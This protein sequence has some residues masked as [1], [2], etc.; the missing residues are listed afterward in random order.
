[1]IIDSVHETFK[2]KFH[3]Y[4]DLCSSRYPEQYPSPARSSNQAA[5]LSEIVWSIY[6]HDQFTRE[7]PDHESELKLV[8]VESTV[9][10]LS[11]ISTFA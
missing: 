7:L 3:L 1:V 9:N 10:S 2:D 8:S 11:S 5:A 4:S 6:L